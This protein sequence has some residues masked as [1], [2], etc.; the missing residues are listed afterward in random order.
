M[1]FLLKF[2]I[3]VFKIALY[4]SKKF[5]KFYIKFLPLFSKIAQTK[6]LQKSL[7]IFLKFLTDFN[8]FKISQKC[9]CNFLKF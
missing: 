5:S 7:I 2:C 8:F 1:Q 6:L 3:K 9:L 4:V